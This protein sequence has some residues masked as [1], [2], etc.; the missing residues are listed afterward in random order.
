[1]TTYFYFSVLILAILLFLPVSKMIWAIS[2]RR[3]QRRTGRLLSPEEIEGQKTRSRFIALL[4]VFPF[5]WFF[6]YSLLG[7]SHG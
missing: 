5:S 4:L 6:N 1:M 7:L 3:L 2:V